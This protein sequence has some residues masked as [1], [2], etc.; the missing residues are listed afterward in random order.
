VRSRAWYA[1]ALIPALVFGVLVVRQAQAIG[2]DIEAMQR[3]VIPGSG[4]VTLRRGDY[5]LF[6]ESETQI[7]G[8]PYT[9]DS[10]TFETPCSLV[11]ATDKPVRLTEVL[12]SHMKYGLRG[13]RGKSMYRA[14]IATE[15][16]YT[17]GC[18]GDGTGD[19]VV[20]IGQGLRYRST[21]AIVLIGAGIAASLL[22][23]FLV[24]RRRQRAQVVQRARG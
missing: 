22:V 3:V 7:A 24:Y 20:A 17:L 19:A 4:T 21:I 1:I 6:G 13:Y 23:G 5:L 18:D 8:A 10:F 11:D 14:T 15:G 9:N 2:D 12:I 16:N